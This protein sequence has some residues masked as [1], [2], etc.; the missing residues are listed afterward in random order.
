MDEVLL[1][2]RDRVAVLT[3]NR[4]EKRNAL[5]AAMRERLDSALHEVASS[6]AVRTAV[7]TGAGEAF[8]AGA[9]IQ[10]MTAYTPEDAERASRHGSRIFAF[11]ESM[12]IPV[13]AAVNGWALG[14]GCELAMACDMRVCSE[15]AVFGQPEIRLGLI[16]GY[17]ASVRLPRLVGMGRALEFILTGRNVKAPEAERIGLANAVHSPDRL[18]PEAMDLARRLAKGPAAMALAKRAVLGAADR[19][20]QAGF[21]MGSRLYGDTYR[22]EDCHEGI[23]AYLEKRR[24]E[25]KGE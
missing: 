7:I 12:D 16:P 20:S 18:M 23:R 11:I 22:T 17:G 24:P 9:D 1:E 13:I 10:A 8:A 15:T 2:V 3:L 6:R 5:N 19:P 21:D 4:P 25:F 14:G